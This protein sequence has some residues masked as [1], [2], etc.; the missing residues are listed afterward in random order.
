MSEHEEGPKK[1]AITDDDLAAVAT[2]GKLTFKT[3]K[4]RKQ[5]FICNQIERLGSLS[6]TQKKIVETQVYGQWKR[7]FCI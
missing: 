4:T 7:H 1:I 2:A 3:L 6:K 5:R